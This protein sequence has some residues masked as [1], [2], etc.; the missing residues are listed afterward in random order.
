MVLEML[1]NKLKIKQ[2]VK[3][4]HS[5]N[6]KGEIHTIYDHLQGVSKYMDVFAIKPDYKSIFKSTGLL[7]DLG[8]YQP[9]FQKY[10]REGGRRGS[11]PH[12]L[13]LC[14]VVGCCAFYN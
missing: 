9:A 4:A 5:E 8:K 7:H 11:V 12:A 1:D 14:F 6:D 13:I 2:S 10:I 3:I